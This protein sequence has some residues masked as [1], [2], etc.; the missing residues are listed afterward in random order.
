M[1]KRACASSLLVGEDVVLFCWS[2]PMGFAMLTLMLDANNFIHKNWMSCADHL[3]FG[4]IR[5]PFRKVCIIF[6]PFPKISVAALPHTMIWSTYCG[7]SRVSPF[8]SATWISVCVVFGLCFHPWDNWFQ[9]YWTSLRFGQ[10]FFLCP[11]SLWCSLV[12][13]LHEK[14]KSPWL[15]VGAAQQQLKHWCVT[16]IIL[17]L[18]PKQSTVLGRTLTQS[19]LKPGQWSCQLNCVFFQ[20]SDR[21]NCSSPLGEKYF[22]EKVLG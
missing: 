8:S 2:H 19:W 9:V 1:P 17:I 7:C 22:S 21:G 12:S 11:F 4:K 3:N 14:M 20:T 16:N 5:L 13:S 18:N 10:L 15:S 6:F